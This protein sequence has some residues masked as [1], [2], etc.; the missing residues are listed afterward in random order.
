MR[1][2][3]IRIVLIAFIYLAKN[4]VYHAKMKHIDVQYYKIRE[5]VLSEQILL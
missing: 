5:L 2:D 3:L 4:K 1:W